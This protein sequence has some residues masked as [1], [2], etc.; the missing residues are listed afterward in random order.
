[1][2]IGAI[3]A[4]DTVTG[5]EDAAATTLFSGTYT[6]AGTLQTALNAYLTSNG[7]GSSVVTMA[8]TGPNAYVWKIVITGAAGAGLA[9]VRAV[10]ALREH[11]PEH[12]VPAAGRDCGV[13]SS[14][15]KGSSRKRARPSVS[16]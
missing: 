13:P 16:V 11:P 3:F 6:T 12:V 2:P 4:T 7:G 8:T 10:A 9:A 15:A 1:M 14:S 5:A